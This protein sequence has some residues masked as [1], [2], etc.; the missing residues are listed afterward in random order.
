MWKMSDY[1]TKYNPNDDEMKFKWNVNKWISTW[2]GPGPNRIFPSILRKIFLS[3][4]APLTLNFN[5]SLASEIFSPLWEDSSIL[6]LLK[7]GDRGVSILLA[8]PKFFY[9]FLLHRLF[10]SWCPRLSMLLF[11]VILLFLVWCSSLISSLVKRNK[12]RQK[13]IIMAFL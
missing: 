2:N 7:A 5:P 13:G 3:V 4:K 8:I 10:D 12:R 6:P 11:G 9:I 1:I